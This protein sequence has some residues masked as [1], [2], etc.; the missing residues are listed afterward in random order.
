VTKPVI[1]MVDWAEALD[2]LTSLHQQ[3]IRALCEGLLD[4][5]ES[6]EHL[7]YAGIAPRLRGTQAALEARDWLRGLQSSGAVPGPAS[8]IHRG[9]AGAMALLTTLLTLIEVQP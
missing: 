9:E 3:Q 7:H 4:A 6:A 1:R 2:R 5:E 8:V